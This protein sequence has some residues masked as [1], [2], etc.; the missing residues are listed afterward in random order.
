M[1]RC[2]SFTYTDLPYDT[3]HTF[4]IRSRNAEGY[5]AWSEEQT[6]KTDLDPWRNTPDPVNIHWTGQVWGAHTPDL[7]FDKIF[8]TG[9]GGFHS[10]Y[11]GV[12]ELLTVDYGKIYNVE[13]IEYYPRTDAGS[14]SVKK[15]RLEISLDGAH[16]TKIGEFSWELKEGLDAKIM[17]V[18]RAAR[19]ARYTA[20]ES[21]GKWFAASEI[22]LCTVEGDKGVATGSTNGNAQVTDGDYTNMKN[23]LGTSVKDGSNFTDQIQKRHG[24]LNANNYYDVYDYAYT[25]FQLDGGTQQKQKLSG[26]SLVSTSKQ[27]VAAGDT[28]TVTYDV[29]SASGVNALGQILPYDPQKVEL[30]SIK[31]SDAIKQMENLCVNKVYEDNTAYVNI[32][33]ANRGDKE[34]YKGTDSLVTVTMKAKE[35]ISTDDSKVL[36]LH[37]LILIGADYTT[38][39]EILE[40]P[41]ALDRKSVV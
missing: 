2:T 30:V 16:W 27:K 40:D 36:D 39:G 7:A 33:Y 10:N 28:F 35:D 12:N 22:K 34:L 38:N 5:S 21:V 14:G 3:E 20:L 11:G 6:L 24:D 26:A 15:M 13:K 4:Q 8:Q 18:N 41:I 1:Q 19:F 17:E 31:A 32:A 25:M 23:Y 9:D 29:K 37:G